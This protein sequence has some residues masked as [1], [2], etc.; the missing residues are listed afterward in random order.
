MVSA[1]TVHYQEVEDFFYKC[2]I[3][4]NDYNKKVFFFLSEQRLNNNGILKTNRN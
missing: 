1:K 4:Q 2:T 3:Q